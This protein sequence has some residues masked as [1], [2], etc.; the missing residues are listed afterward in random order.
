MRQSKPGRLETAPTGRPLG[1]HC[2]KQGQGR[3]G[4]IL[5]LPG[6]ESVYLF[7][8]F[9][10][11]I[12]AMPCPVDSVLGASASHNKVPLSPSIGY[13]KNTIPMTTHGGN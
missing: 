6:S 10:I 7:L 8:E 13:Y 1:R 12:G 11:L 9:T 4:R 3:A 5:P 2:F